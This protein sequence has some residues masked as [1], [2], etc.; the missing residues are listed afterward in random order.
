[1]W[2]SG[3]SF[4]GK[5]NESAFLSILCAK[6]V[7]RGYMI[8]IKDRLQSGASKSNIHNRTNVSTDKQITKKQ[9]KEK[10]KKRK[11]ACS[12]VFPT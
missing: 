5:Y 1:M 6:W 10:K 9:N 12:W 8:G 3:T 4:L 11:G 7:G 2:M